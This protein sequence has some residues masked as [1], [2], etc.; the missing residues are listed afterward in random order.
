MPEFR[1]RPLPATPQCPLDSC[2]QAVG[3]GQPG[4]QG[5]C[6]RLPRHE[7]CKN[8]LEQVLKRRRSLPS[9]GLSDEQSWWWWWECP[10]LITDCKLECRGAQRLIQGYVASKWQVWNLNAVCLGSY[11]FQTR[12]FSSALFSRSCYPSIKQY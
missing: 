11:L 4:P 1:P 2:R 9:R 10:I 7:S 3:V 6:G 8:M 5:S 12:A